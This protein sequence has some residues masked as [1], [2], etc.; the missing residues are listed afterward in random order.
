MPSDSK[1]YRVYQE[2]MRFYRVAPV[3]GIVLAE[4][5]DYARL[6][7]FTGR[8]LDN[9]W[10]DDAVRDLRSAFD[11]FAA[12]FRARHGETLG[13]SA[14]SAFLI[15]LKVFG[16]DEAVHALPAEVDARVARIWDEFVVSRDGGKVAYLEDPSGKRTNII[17]EI[18]S[19]AKETMGSRPFF[20]AFIY[21]SSPEVDGWTALHEKGRMKLVEKVGPTVMSQA[22]FDCNNDAAFDAAVADATRRRADLIVTVSPTQ[23][24]SCLRA[25]VA[26]PELPIINCSV[27]LSH[28]AVRTFA[29]RLYEAK[30]LLGALAASMAKNHRV[31]YVAENPVYGTV[32]EINAFAIGARMID[33][34][35]TVYLKWF[36]TKDYDWKR[37]LAESDVRVVSARDYLD[38]SDPDEPWGLYEIMDDGTCRHLAEPIWKWGR[39][40]ALIVRS[41]RNDSWK[42]EGATRRGEALNYWWGMSAGVLD[43]RLSDEV[44]Y[45]QRV[46]VEGIRQSIL[47]RRINPFAGEL[48]SQG[49]T[50]VHTGPDRL[51]SEEIVRMR[52]LNENIVGRLPEQRE[53]SQA[54]LEQVEV[55][56]VIPLDPTKLPHKGTLS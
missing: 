48:V 39:Y 41:I 8:D 9:S 19:L 42:K 50:L 29:G 33:P 21:E 2:F 46:L 16:Y 17:P 37:E 35:V 20:A 53:L 10:P 56:G 49:G 55:S 18:K 27:S 6:A 38:P 24:R 11:A 28:S 54:G 14:G 1:A 43:V 15:Y 26:H 3:F 47:T 25:A 30:F 7:A 45:G 22:Y 44:P 52:W 4:E 51:S 40:Y 31:G 5:G 13:M 34:Y 32:A 12:A 23:M 36:S